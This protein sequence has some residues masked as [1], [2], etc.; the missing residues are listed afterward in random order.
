MPKDT[1]RVA[2]DNGL[3]MLAVQMAGQFPA[4]LRD[5]EYVLRRIRKIL[6][7]NVF[8]EEPFRVTNEPSPSGVTRLTVVQR[9]DRAF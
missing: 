9:T 4:N 5:A 3:K 8:D 2:Y 7:D 6:Y 1:E